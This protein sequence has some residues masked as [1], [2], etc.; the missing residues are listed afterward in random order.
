MGT[1]HTCTGGVTVGPH[2]DVSSGIES[3]GVLA[4]EAHNPRK[5][6]RMAVR[7]GMS[8][9]LTSCIWRLHTDYPLTISLLSYR[10]HLCPV[11]P[12]HRSQRKPILTPTPRSRLARWPHGR[13]VA[14]CRHVH[15]DWRQGVAVH[16]QRRRHDF[17]LVVG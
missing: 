4:G 11:H 13:I 16:H 1:S 6:M 3:I 8:S 17:G 9:S 2:A 10:R 15:P 14:F 12:R 7:T 5:T